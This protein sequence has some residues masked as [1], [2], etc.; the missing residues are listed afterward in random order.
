MAFR[1]VSM[2]EVK[3]VLRGWL[4]GEAKKALARRTG[5]SRNTVK[6]YIRA[7]VKCGLCVGSGPA[8]LTEEV[9]GA[10][11]GLLKAPPAVAHGESWSLVETHRQFVEGKLGEGV[12]LTKVGRLLKRQGVIVPYATLHRFAVK[13]LGFGQGAPTIPVSDCAPA[14]EVQLDTGWM[15]MLEPDVFGKRRRF[16]AWIFTAVYSRHRFVY[17]CFEETT[18]GA[19]EAC[20]A[21]WAFF[22]GVFLVVI[23]DGTKAIVTKM[24]PLAPVINETFLE[25]SQARGF[26]VDPARSR[27]PKDKGRV[28]RAVQPVREDCFRGERLLT[29]EDCRRRSVHWCLEEY[30]LRRHTRT[31]RLPLEAFE[32]D[33]KPA[34]LPAPTEIYDVPTYCDPKVAIDQHAQV[35]KALYSLAFEYRRKTLRARADRSTVRFYSRGQLIE[36]HPRQPPGGRSTKPEHFPPEKLAYAQRDAS[37]LLRQAKEQGPNVERFAQALLDGPQPWTRMRQLFGLLGLCRRFT[38]KRVEETCALALAAEMHDYRRLERM[39]KL[40]QV[41][42]PS[43]TPTPPNNVVPISRFLRP[44]QHY[45]LPLASREQAAP[46][47]GPDNDD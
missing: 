1:E 16:R 26:T 19:I 22:G 31:Q 40:G 33:E 35:A 23:P 44:A 5:L 14:A 28:E 25:Y 21:A 34:L 12:L 10:V 7:A 15:T 13:E 46:K 27:S 3:E 32:A 24:D 38:P 39:V 9:L 17:P 47:E 37:F 36:V 45:A 41:A 43:P 20:E 6:S 42:T 2:L 8:A 4:A 30:G 18:K 11:L 29:I